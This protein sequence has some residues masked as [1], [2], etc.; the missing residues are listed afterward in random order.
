MYPRHSCLRK[1]VLLGIIATFATIAAIACGSS[2]GSSEVSTY[3]RERN[4]ELT[5]SMDDVRDIGFK[6]IRQ[7]D[8]QG[9]TG[10]T[11]AWFGFRR[12]AGLDPTE[13]EIR[14]Y[15]SHD[16][17]IEDGAFFAQDVI[18][19]DGNIFAK[20]AAWKTGTADRWSYRVVNFDSINAARF[21]K[22][23]DYV[24]VGNLIVLCE[25]LDADTSQEACDWMAAQLATA[26]QG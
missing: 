19:R 20:D 25:G 11:E 10:A 16:D 1:S 9:L 5:L 15:P 17:A 18:G 26:G 13:Y 7:Y 8:V 4:P 14:T 24:I 12:V 6:T 21:P 23:H 2:S 22:Y 3:V